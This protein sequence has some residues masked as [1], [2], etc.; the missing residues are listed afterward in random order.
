LSLFIPYHETPH[1]TKMVTILHFAPNSTWSFLNAFKAAAKPLPRTALVAEM[2]RNIEVTR[3]VASLLPSAISGGYV[4][5]TLVS[6]HTSILLEYIS[7]S[8][9]MDSN[10]SAVLL[11]PSIDS[12]KS[13]NT[14]EDK[15]GL[16][17]DVV[18]RRRSAD[19]R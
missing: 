18:V 16:D 2:L 12:I 1:F 6:F 5:R 9:A 7:Q 3:F 8:K 19:V 13:A 10:S 4:H 15:D 11:P 14:I 17:K